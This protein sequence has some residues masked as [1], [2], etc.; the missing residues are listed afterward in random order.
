MLRRKGLI[1][2]PDVVVLAGFFCGKDRYQPRVRGRSLHRLSEIGQVGFIG[3][4][5][6]VLTRCQ[7]CFELVQVR[8]NAEIVTGSF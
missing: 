2:V 7:A 4:D 8:R 5:E 6:I 1:D 3:N